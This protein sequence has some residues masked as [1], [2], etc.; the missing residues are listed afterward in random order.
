MFRAIQKSINNFEAKLEIGDSNDTCLIQDEFYTFD[1]STTSFA[2]IDSVSSASIRKEKSFLSGYGYLTREQEE[3]FL[4][5]L[6]N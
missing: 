5:Y 4:H 1:S 6:T 2:L 3:A